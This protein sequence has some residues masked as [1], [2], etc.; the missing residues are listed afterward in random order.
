VLKIG[1]KVESREHRTA[2]QLQQSLTIY[3]VIAWRLLVLT[4]LGQSVPERDASVFFT[5]AELGFLMAYARTVKLPEPKTIKDAILLVGVLGGYQ[6]KGRA[7]RPPG[8][9]IMWTGVE[10]L[11]PAMLGYELAVSLNCCCCADS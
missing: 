10:R 6:N 8:H 3:L 11:Y 5:E 7:P 2:L 1:C 4:L 9:Q